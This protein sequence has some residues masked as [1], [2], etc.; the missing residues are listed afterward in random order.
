MSTTLLDSAS[1]MLA[2]FGT[3]AQTLVNELAAGDTQGAMGT[4][5]YLAGM[6]NAG[7]QTLRAQVAVNP[8]LVTGGVGGAGPFSTTGEPTPGVD[9]PS[10]GE[11]E[12]EPD[13]PAQKHHTTNNPGGRH[14]H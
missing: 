11:V 3:T 6:S 8:S 14:K 2:S 9:E 12:P 1:A 5:N 4:A 7:I 13:D 10:P